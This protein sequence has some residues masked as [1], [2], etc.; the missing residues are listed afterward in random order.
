MPPAQINEIA[1][2]QKVMD[3]GNIL[4]KERFQKRNQYFSVNGGVTN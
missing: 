4:S 2:I 1:P 3:F